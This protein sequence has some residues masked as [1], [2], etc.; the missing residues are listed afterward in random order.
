MKTGS[1]H[2]FSFSL[3]H[4]LFFSYRCVGIVFVKKTFWTQFISI[5]SWGRRQL[6][7]GHWENIRPGPAG[8]VVGNNWYRKPV[9]WTRFG[10]IS[11]S[12]RAYNATLHPD[13][14]S[15]DFPRF[16]PSWSLHLIRSGP[17]PLPARSGGYTIS[18]P[19]YQ[20]LFFFLPSYLFLFPLPASY[21][22][23]WAGYNGT[24]WGLNQLKG[25]FL[26]LFLRCSNLT[27][28]FHVTAHSIVNIRYHLRIWVSFFPFSVQF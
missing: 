10:N 27:T 2:F 28:L 4:R 15:S 1:V 6:A 21:V 24:N 23:S 9:T 12:L 20:S 18:S 7:P 25:L 17:Y 13:A 3:D 5:W 19:S 14:L 22:L 26:V 11:F 16:S 8:S